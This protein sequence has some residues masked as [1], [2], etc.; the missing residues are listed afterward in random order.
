MHKGEP[1][2]MVWCSL[3]GD[4]DEKDDSNHDLYLLLTCI[5]AGVLPLGV[6][7][8]ITGVDNLYTV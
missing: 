6:V 8:H 4:H 1:G 7:Y 3:P 2:M 5:L